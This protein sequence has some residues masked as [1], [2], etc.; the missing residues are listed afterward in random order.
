MQQSWVSA[1]QPRCEGVKANR[2]RLG[3]RL[4]D[5]CAELEVSL[6][7]S[8]HGTSGL[9]EEASRPVILASKA[10]CGESSHFNCSEPSLGWAGEDGKAQSHGV[11]TLHS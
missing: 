10:E 3:L 8:W 9:I 2:L 7:V 5:E 4:Q 6:Q 1:S 11:S